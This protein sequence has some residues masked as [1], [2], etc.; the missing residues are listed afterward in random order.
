MRLFDVTTGEEVRAFPTRSNNPPSIAITA[1]GQTFAVMDDDGTVRLWEVATGKERLVIDKHKVTPPVKRG[2]GPDV[3]MV[4]A[5]DG[6]MLATGNHEGG[7]FLWDVAH[8]EIAAH[9]GG[10]TPRPWALSPH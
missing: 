7:I 2:E 6:K 10:G 4:F 3:R 8:G 1:D 5:P 9:A